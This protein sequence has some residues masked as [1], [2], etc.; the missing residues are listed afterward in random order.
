MVTTSVLLVGL[1]IALLSVSCTSSSQ[2]RVGSPSIAAEAR[3]TVAV[4][5]PRKDTVSQQVTLTGEFRPYQV[6]D[7]H[8]KVAGYL[9]QIRVD[10]G[11]QVKEGDLIAVLEIPEM[12]AELAQAAAER[13]RA[14]AELLRSRAELEKSVRSMV[15]AACPSRPSR[16][17]ERTS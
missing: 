10:V 11:S 13:A 9:R 15:G 1:S 6:A 7:L 8:A 14:E 16:S 2:G 5:K 12:Q 3:S 17:S 4:A